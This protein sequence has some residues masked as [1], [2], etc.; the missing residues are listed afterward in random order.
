MALEQVH[1][2]QT[3]YLVG[4]GPSLERLTS[5]HIGQGPVI[6]L[7]E[8]I[9]KVCGLHIPNP[10]YSMQVDGCVWRDPTNTPR[11]CDVCDGQ[12]AAR[13][14]T[15]PAID[16]PAHVAVV[17]N[18]FYS[19]QCLRN[20]DN[21]FVF[22]WGDGTSTNG[23]PWMSVLC[24]IDLA[25]WMGCTRIVMCCFDSLTTGDLATVHA[26]VTGASEWYDA[27]KPHV[28]TALENIDHEWVTP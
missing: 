17:L 9:W 2:G 1:T 21:R 15:R 4:K 23:R 13:D 19:G 6:A 14:Q 12:Y 16:P 25:K 7:N 26:G 3:A 10:T 28:L 20:R 11:P 8:A 27:V 24:A 5:E 18:K 22:E